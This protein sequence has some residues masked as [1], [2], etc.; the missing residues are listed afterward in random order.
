MLWYL[1][2]IVLPIVIL[3]TNHYYFSK[4]TKVVKKV[5]GYQFIYD[6]IIIDFDFNEIEYVNHYVSP[7]TYNKSLDFIGIGDFSIV[8]IFLKNEK[9]LTF[10]TFLCDNPAD[11][12]SMAQVIRKKKFFPLITRAVSK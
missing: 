1:I 10:S 4:K 11:V 8:R 12:F 7:T 5:N 2:V 6:D 9:K 3:F